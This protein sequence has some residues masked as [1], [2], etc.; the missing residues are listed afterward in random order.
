MEVKQALDNTG[1]L[2]FMRSIPLR[3]SYVD[4]RI[5][6]ALHALRGRGGEAEGLA[7]RVT[8]RFSSEGTPFYMRL[9]QVASAALRAEICRDQGVDAQYVEAAVELLLQYVREDDDLM[10]VYAAVI[11]SGEAASATLH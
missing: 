10:A 3:P 8:Q 5:S 2:D 9:N 1:M 7:D 6:V 11:E 4:A